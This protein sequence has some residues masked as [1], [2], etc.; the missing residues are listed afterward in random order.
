MS[1]TISIEQVVQALQCQGDGHRVIV[2]YSADE[3]RNIDVQS[4]DLLYVIIS[5]LAQT[6]EG[7]IGESNQPRR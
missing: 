7:P 2:T 4:M 5:E 3:R 1:K 6:L